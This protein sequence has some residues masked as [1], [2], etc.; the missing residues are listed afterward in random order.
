MNKLLTTDT[1]DSQFLFKE[2]TNR[3]ALIKKN[4]N[5]QGEKDQNFML[6]QENNFNFSNQGFFRNKQMETIQT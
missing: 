3:V 5:F 6:V 4:K 1:D 2:H